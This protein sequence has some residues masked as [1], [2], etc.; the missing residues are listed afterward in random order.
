MI[1]EEFLLYRNKANPIIVPKDFPG[2][3]AD[4]VRNCGQTM[5]GEETILL[6]SVDHRAD[7][8]NGREGRTTH[9]ARSPDGIHFKIDPK[10]FLSAPTE[11]EE[12]LYS[13]VD[14]HPIDTRLTRIGDDYYICRP[15]GGWRAKWGTCVLLSRT[16]DFKT[17]EYVGIVGL[18]ENRGASLFPEKINGYYA[19]LDR[20]YRPGDDAENGNLWISYSPDLI[21]WGQHR[22]VLACGYTTWAWYKIG[23]TPPIRTEKGW[24]VIIHGVTGSCAGKRY[25]IG[26]ILLDPDDP[27]RVIGKAR[28]FLLAPYEW[29]EQTGRVPNV[30]FPCGAIPDYADDRLR[31][32]YGAADTCVCLA[33]GSISEIVDACLKGL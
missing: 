19:R 33:T 23:P 10:P 14:Q 1:H 32:Y 26:A 16:R 3:G 28:S 9:V 29:Y 31:V 12:P 5:L 2:G 18:P 30:V 13:Q 17:H 22:P 21:H 25:L 11:A 8:I 24:L 7:G 6:I 20:P 15:G 4:G 27:A